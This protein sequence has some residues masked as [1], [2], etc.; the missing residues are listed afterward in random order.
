M[1]VFQVLQE[2]LEA[3]YKACAAFI[4]SENDKRIKRALLLNVRTISEVRYITGNTVLY[5]GDNS[6]KWRGP[7]VVIGQVSRQI[8]VK[9]GSF[10]IRAH[11]YML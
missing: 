8:F 2:N 9:H 10:Y 11:P 7:G 5:K 1:K 6:S 4:A 3:M